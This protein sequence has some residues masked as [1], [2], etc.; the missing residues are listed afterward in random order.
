VEAA[1]N[2]HPRP[3]SGKIASVYDEVALPYRPAPTRAQLE[4]RLGSK[5]QPDRD[6]AKVLLEWL[7]RDG[8]FPDHY[9]YPVQVLHLGSDLVLIGLASE[10]VVDYSLRLKREV[11]AR[12]VWVAGYCNDFMG[13][14]PSRRVWEEGGYEG[15]GS[16]TYRRDTMYRIVH[17]NIWDSSVEERIVGKVHELHN[18]IARRSP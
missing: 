16:L 10:T 12:A 18:R 11:A 6:Y 9:S 2:A 8:R 14:I 4:E 13:Y 15:G 5:S 3:L 1:L 17:P 7:Q